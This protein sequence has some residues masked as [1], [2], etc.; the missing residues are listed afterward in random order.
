V[1]VRR[2]YGSVG[3]GDYVRSPEWPTFHEVVR[4]EK[5]IGL[6]CI[7]IAVGGLIEKLPPRPTH[8][9]IETDEEAM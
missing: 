1:I 2:P 3:V 8:E 6:V 7:D 5:Q 9:L 4:V